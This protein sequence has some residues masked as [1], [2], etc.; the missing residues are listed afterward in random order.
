M[1]ET[2]GTLLT[3]NIDLTRLLPLTSDVKT[4]IPPVDLCTAV[5][6]AR[7]GP[8]CVARTIAVARPVHAFCSH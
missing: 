8:G 1:V 6:D 3:Q 4:P 5:G 2:V 7:P